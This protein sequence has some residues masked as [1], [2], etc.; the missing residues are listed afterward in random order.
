MALLETSLISLLWGLTKHGPLMRV[1]LWRLVMVLQLLLV[2]SL[3]IFFCVTP[4]KVYKRYSI[5]MG[6]IILVLATIK[7]TTRLVWLFTSNALTIIIIK[8]LRMVIIYGIAM[9]I[10][11][12]RWLLHVHCIKNIRYKLPPAIVLPRPLIEDH[13]KQENS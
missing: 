9:L 11:Y 12:L 3:S 5:S 4:L 7:I 10:V 1:A 8:T 2:P 13:E 6:I